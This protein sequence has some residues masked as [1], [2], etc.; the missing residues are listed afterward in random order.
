MPSEIIVQSFLSVFTLMSFL[1]TL[2]IAKITNKLDNL[3][4]DKDFLKPQS[5]HNKSIPRSGGVAAIILLCIFYFF[6]YHLFKETLY[7]YIF[8]SIGLFAIGFLDDIKINIKPTIRLS[9]M[10]VTIL[11]I[12]LIFSIRL[13]AVDLFFLKSLLENS[14]FSIF[15]LLLC[16]LFIINGS[17]LIDGFNGLLIIH[18][19]IIN[20]IL[21]IINLTN[22][23]ETL[24]IVILGQVIILFS[25]LLFNFPKAQIFMGDS[26]AYLFG[27]LVAYNVINTNNL[28]PEISSFFFCVILFYLFFEVFFS[29]FRKIKL[30]KSPLK[31]DNLHLHMIIYKNL[32]ISKKFKDCNFMTTLFINIIYLI[33]ILPLINFK[34]NNLVCLSW[35]LFLIIF[36]TLTYIRLNKN[37]IR[38]QQ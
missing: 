37:L 16:F 21:L 27:T 2:T 33:V 19:L 13:Q 25:L 14:F 35:F 8:L 23:H 11:S 7:E 34:H 32:K 31:P 29:F 4:L 18:L 24:S 15:F 36:Y 30:K 26:G 22:N 28:N 6:F 9:I 38:S 1:V 17:N 10:I 3:L 5:F 20:L 12:L